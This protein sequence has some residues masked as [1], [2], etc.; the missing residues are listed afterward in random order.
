M[1][2]ATCSASCRVANP[3]QSSAVT[4]YRK[5]VVHKSQPCFEDLEDEGWV[6]SVVGASSPLLASVG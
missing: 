4:R 2:V 3:P 6:S 1:F 5:L